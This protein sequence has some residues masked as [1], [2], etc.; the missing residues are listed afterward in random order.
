MSEQPDVAAETAASEA[1]AEALNQP[2]E[3]TVQPQQPQEG[4][5]TLGDDAAAPGTEG[6][7]EKPKPKTAQERIDEIT[8][9]RHAEARRADAAEQELVRLRANQP[10]EPDPE[11]APAKSEDGRPD[12]EDYDFGVADERYL[13][14]L[15]DWKADQAV[16]KA[17]GQRDARHHAGQVVQ[18]FQERATKA[19]PTGEPE[20]LKAYRALEK[21]P[22]AV[23][24]VVLASEVGHKIAEHLGSNQA[25]LTRLAGL[26][27][28]MQAYELGKLEA[29][30]T[31]NP[32]PSPKPVSDAPA[33]P[34]TVARG[35]G[36]KFTVPADTDDFAAFDKQ[37]G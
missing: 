3:Q 20:G 22:A 8:A 24:D 6:E 12:P 19:Y 37:Y 35:A 5:P 4:A 9:Q 28:H 10:K 25:E 32:A 13:E 7:A 14:D 23:Q 18:S 31:A 11:P 17:L 33:P 29:R 27:P 36:G 15:T 26:A 21:V 30:F 16:Q 1:A 2:Q 34:T